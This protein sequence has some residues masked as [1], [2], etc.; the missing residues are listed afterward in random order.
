MLKHNLRD[1]SRKRA[2][3]K[4]DCMHLNPVRAGLV[5][6]ATDWAWSSARN[7]EHG[8]SVGVPLEWVF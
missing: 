2:V 6:R 8:K 7:F 3:E 4:I 1:Y 5:E